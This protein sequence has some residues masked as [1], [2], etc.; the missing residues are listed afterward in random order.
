[1]TVVIA[2][3]RE[4]GTIESK[5][6]TLAGQTYPAGLLD[7]VLVCDGSDDGTAE[8]ARRAGERLVPGRLRVIEVERGGKPA[9]LNAG[10]AAARGEVLVLT[11]ARQQMNPEAIEAL[12]RDLYDP[13]VGA[14]SGELVLSGG[15]G[16]GA[17][18][19]YEAW[20]RRNEGRA[21]SVIGVSG[22][23]Y[24]IRRELFTPLPPET[25]LDDLLVPMRV[26][27]KGLRVGFQ[28]EARAYDTAAEDAREFS[29]KAR[30]L[31]GNFQLLL[32]M[33]ELLLPGKN[34]SWF[35]FVSH[36][37]CRLLVPYALLLVLVSDLFLCLSGG[38]ALPWLLLWGQAG[39]YGLSAVAGSSVGQRL[40]LLRLSRT[41]VVLNAAAVV[42]LYRVL[43]HGKQQRWT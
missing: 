7:V 24:A 29:R 40:G 12:C 30:T 19:R 5:L 39:A 1:V 34:P 16:A 27:Q 8:V 28:P 42:G 43:R 15:A 3:Y 10:A 22:A 9:A 37:L 2:A 32:L 38:G 31:A 11:D 17:Y 23:L 6:R 35:G 41:F 21:G 14:V 33:P 18:W 26:R 13:E 20:I 36:K 4:A 25:L